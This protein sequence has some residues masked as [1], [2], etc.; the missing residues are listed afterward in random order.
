[1][2]CEEFRHLE[3]KISK[4]ISY[5]ILE[6]YRELC[7][8]EN[9]IERG[10]KFLENLTRLKRVPDSLVSL[11]NLYVEKLKRV[12]IFQRTILFNKAENAFKEALRIKSTHWGALYA[13]GKLYLHSPSF[14][15]KQKEAILIFEKLLKLQEGRRDEPKYVKTYIALA[16]SYVKTNNK[17]KARKLCLEGLKLF[18]ENK[19]L[20]KRLKI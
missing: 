10:I 2:R 12:D 15:R 1:M 11:G 16:D 19:E 3:E 17:D 20:K 7:I 6:K 13:L 4:E 14:L 5:K 9:M 18:P 8:Q